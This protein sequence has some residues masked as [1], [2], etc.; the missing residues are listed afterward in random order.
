MNKESS[1]KKIN[2][3][4]KGYTEK[5]LLDDFYEIFIM[6]Q[7]AVSNFDYETIEEYCSENLYNRYKKLLDELEHNKCHNK[8]TS[9][10]LIKSSIKDI[11]KESNQIKIDTYFEISLYD[12]VVDK[13]KNILYGNNKKKT[14]N[15]Y[16]L[17]FIKGMDKNDSFVLDN[18]SLI[19]N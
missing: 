1:K 15:C 12:Y 17:E 10:K 8:I 7:K 19:C 3:Y 18:R 16:N 9:F 5:K 4:L 6:I 14:I 13:D 2:K 11:K